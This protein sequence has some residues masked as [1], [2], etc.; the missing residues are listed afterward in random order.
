MTKLSF[1]AGGSKIKRVILVLLLC[2][3]LF[4]W[5]NSL[6]TP[7]ITHSISDVVVN[8]FDEVKEDGGKLVS[9]GPLPEEVYNNPSA[10]PKEVIDKY[11][12][13]FNTTQTKWRY[14][15]YVRKA[16]HLLEYFS[17]GLLCA[18]YFFFDKITLT[19]FKRL[20]LIGVVVPVTDEI[21][22]KFCDRTANLNDVVTDFSGY[23]VGVGA[24]VLIMYLIRKRQ[25]KKM[26]QK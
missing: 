3:L 16:A 1:K 14:R 7:D 13:V 19:G 20:A 25:A 9:S 8:M 11:Q 6:L 17:F 4:I 15:S 26:A 5:G 22:Q 2:N 18:I 23:A 12:D 24:A 10:P 21:I